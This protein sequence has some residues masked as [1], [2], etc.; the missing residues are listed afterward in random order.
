M[1]ASDNH[2]ARR[3][4]IHSPAA[5]SRRVRSQAP[6]SGL[7]TV[8]GEFV[9]Q[10]M[11][12]ALLHFKRIF[13]HD[14]LLDLRGKHR[15]GKRRHFV[16]ASQLHRTM[17]LFA[18]KRRG[19]VGI[20]EDMECVPECFA[21]EDM[22][23]RV[24]LENVENHVSAPGKF[25]DALPLSEKMSI[26]RQAGLGG[27]AKMETEHRGTAERIAQGEVEAMGAE[28]RGKVGFGE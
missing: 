8:R 18:Q 14:R 11:I 7:F 4:S 15:E 25:A 3:A 2:A 26:S 22:L 1:P 16:D 12:K 5:S 13:N 19:A 21:H 27:I 20:E 23:R 6:T 24:L 10:L 17:L 28:Q 9:P